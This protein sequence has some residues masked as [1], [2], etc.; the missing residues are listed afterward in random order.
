MVK[1]FWRL[2]RR[3]RKIITASEFNEKKQGKAQK[4]D[5]I[6][7]EPEI[8]ASEKKNKNKSGVLK[9]GKGEKINK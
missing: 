3:R 1:K 9:R 2:R 4:F 8:E 5:Y 7:F 6:R